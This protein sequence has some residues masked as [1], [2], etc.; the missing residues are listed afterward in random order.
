MKLVPYLTFEGNCEEALEFYRESLGG[1]IVYLERYKDAPVE[2]EKIYAEKIFHSK[3]KFGKNFILAS[4]AFEGKIVKH[5]DHISLSLEF[6]SVEEIE[7]IFDNLSDDA[8]IIIPLQESFWGTMF[9]TLTDKFGITWNL[10]YIKME[11]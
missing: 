1:E 9:A 2:V 6:G 11:V 3:L 4:D 5:G 8:E 7:E 10:N